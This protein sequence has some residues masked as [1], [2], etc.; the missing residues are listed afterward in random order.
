LLIQHQKTEVNY[1]NV[2]VDSKLLDELDSQLLGYAILAC[3][4]GIGFKGYAY[5]GCSLGK[6]G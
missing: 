4:G 3:L 1:V 6:V 5:L 2:S